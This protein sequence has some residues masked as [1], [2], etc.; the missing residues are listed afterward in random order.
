MRS[1]EELLRSCVAG[2]AAAR[3]Q[4]QDEYGEEIYNF[5]LKIYRVPA[6]RAAD[7]YV[8]VFERDRIFSRLR[9]FE[10]RN[11]IQFRTFLAFYVLES[12]FREWQRTHHDLDTVS[13][14]EPSGSD[15]NG[16]PLE[17]VLVGSKHPIG[18]ET[19][20][21]SNEHVQRLWS[22]LGPESRL[23]LKL[24]SLAEHDLDPE[25]VRQLAQ[26]AGRSIQDTIALVSEVLVA[27]RR[28]DEKLSGLRDDL[29]SVWG[30][31]RLRRRE[32]DE[33]EEK[34]QLVPEAASSTRQ[35]LLEKRD[36]LQAMVI[37]RMRQREKILAEIREFKSTTPYKDI[38]RLTNL[39]VGTVC[40]RIFRLRQ[41]LARAA[42]EGR[43]N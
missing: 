7:F 35:R 25:E 3:R 22:A 36:H 33:T 6:D 39:T 37:K 2:E 18:D 8:Y 38:A 5:P 41:R 31:I 27:L 16:R 11:N 20:S 21:A 1:L 10:G 34:I 12:L 32:L 40:S 17:D 28:R 29:D 14:S 42:L 19:G 13:L 15:P 9:T 43:R 23:D 26:L 24:L 4:F 30:W